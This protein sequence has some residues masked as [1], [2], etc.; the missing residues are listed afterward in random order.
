MATMDRLENS[1]TVY[2]PEKSTTGET[3]RNPSTGM[4]VM[5]YTDRT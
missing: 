4:I 3:V 5:Q 1:A 2:F